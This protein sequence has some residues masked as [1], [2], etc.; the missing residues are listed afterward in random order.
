VQISSESLRSLAVQILNDSKASPFFYLE[1]EGEALLSWGPISPNKDAPKI[2][3]QFFSPVS[4]K[5]NFWNDFSPR[6][7]ASLE[8]F[9]YKNGDTLKTNLKK[10]E[11][12]GSIAEK[13]P[14]LR[15]L[16]GDRD[17]WMSYCKKIEG[18]IAKGELQKLVPARF[19]SQ[20]AS[21]NIPPAEM[22]R[23]LFLVN[24]PHAHLFCFREHT[25]CF[26]GAT[27]ELLF[28]QSGNTV[29]VPAI[30]GT[31]SIDL[32]PKSLLE[33]PKE[34]AEHEFVVRFIEER[35]LK[36]GAKVRLPNIPEILRLR[37]LQHLFTPIHGSFSSAPT[38]ANLIE[39]LH[40]TPAMAG[41]PQK[42]ARDFIEKEEPWTRGLYAAPLGFSWPNGDGKCVVGIRSMLISSNLVRLFAGAGYV[43]GSNPEAEWQETSQKM[44]TMRQVFD[45]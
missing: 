21:T 39:T 19:E 7:H 31:K 16:H 8:N 29:F 24:P 45:T 1:S 33:S 11:I 43:N 42:E 32:D 38:V 30:A 18:A 40:P 20:E 35:L 28:R 6:F 27:P 41:V 37:Q 23:K 5:E 26:M 15:A 22:L 36:I 2:Y 3:S 13:I 4:A 25:D 12:K 17:H 34:R 14:V 44:Q 10:I 9:I